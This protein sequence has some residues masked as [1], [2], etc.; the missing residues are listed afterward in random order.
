MAGIGSSKNIYGD[1]LGKPEGRRP[2]EIPRCRWEYTVKMDLK[3][4]AC[5]A[6]ELTH[7]GEGLLLTWVRLNLP[8]KLL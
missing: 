7:H 6:L 8:I 5:D 3:K 1:L 2:L 4:T